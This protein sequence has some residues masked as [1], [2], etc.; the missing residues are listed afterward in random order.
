MISIFEAQQQLNLDR[1]KMRQFLLELGIAFPLHY[2]EEDFQ[3]GF[4]ANRIF[5]QLTTMKNVS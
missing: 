2:E 3:K 1:I 4:I 5:E